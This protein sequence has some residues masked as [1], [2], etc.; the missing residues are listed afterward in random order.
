MKIGNTDFNIKAV[1]AMSLKQFKEQYS[2]LLKGV[3]VSD[4]Y[5]SITGKK[6]R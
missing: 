5:Y 2:T 1:K 3:G 6:R 4:A